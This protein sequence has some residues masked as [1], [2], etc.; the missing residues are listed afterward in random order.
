MYTIRGEVES[1]KQ[2][3]GDDDGIIS[4]CLTVYL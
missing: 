1:W 3:I 2:A 4:D